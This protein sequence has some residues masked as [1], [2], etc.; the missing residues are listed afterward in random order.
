MKK[1]DLTE[2]KDFIARNAKERAELQTKI[3]KLSADRDQYV[4]E[5]RKETAG[6]ATLDTAVIS[7]VH[8]QGAKRNLVFK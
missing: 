1:M 7:A 6:V 4:A 5:R 8:E 2:R 3:Q